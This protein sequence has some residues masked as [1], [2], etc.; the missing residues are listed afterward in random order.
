MD[1]L[2]SGLPYVFV[3]LDDMLVAS[4][5]MAAHLDHLCSLL[6]I[7]RDNG[8]LVNLNKCTFAWHQVDFLGHHVTA[9][10]IAH[11]EAIR[12]FPQLA[13]IQTCSGSWV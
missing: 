12:A 1:R 3:Y 11:V 10:G 9:T 2:L 13:T 8:L 5:T 6:T 7:F 4:P